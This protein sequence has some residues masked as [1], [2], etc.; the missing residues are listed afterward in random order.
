MKKII[1]GF[2]TF[3]IFLSCKKEQTT[4]PVDNTCKIN[5]ATIA[6]TYTK[7]AIKYKASSS[8]VEQ[9]LFSGLQPCEQDDTYEL[10]TDG[11][12][13]VGGGAEVCPGPPPP[14]TITVWTLSADGKVFTLDALYDVVSFDCTTLVVVEVNSLIPGDIR[15]VTY[16]KK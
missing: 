2:T 4:P 10:K 9:D 6:G 1:L 12:V 3:L 14:G 15:T 13:V 8:A 11:S 5:S 16:K 7:T